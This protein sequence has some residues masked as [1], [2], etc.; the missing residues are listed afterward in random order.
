MLFLL[1]ILYFAVSFIV[2][3]HTKTVH[4]SFMALLCFPSWNT[5]FN[6]HHRKS[7]YQFS[8]YLTL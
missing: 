5:L 1:S 3:H 6:F 2:T 8:V 4:H 7:E